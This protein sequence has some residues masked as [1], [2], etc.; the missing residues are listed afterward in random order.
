VYLAI[1]TSK[2]KGKAGEEE[3]AEGVRKQEQILAV[4]AS[5]DSAALYKDRAV[6]ALVLE[7]ALGAGDLRIAAP[8][9]KAILLAL[10]EK[11]PTAEP[12]L[13][14]E[15]H[16]EPDPDLRDYENVPLKEDIEAYFHR[17]V[18]PHVPDAWISEEPRDRD[19]KDRGVGRV[20]YEINFNRY[21][22]EYVPP[23][24]LSVIDQEIG[25][26]EEEVAALLGSA[27]R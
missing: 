21:F 13:D 26:L 19:K 20:G 25:R 6:F 10:A 27:R 18:L 7:D 12:C 17:E 1:A 11:D 8:V 24:E 5:M 15:G 14:T 9:R 4:L 23:R 2:K 22:Y 16:P 3:I